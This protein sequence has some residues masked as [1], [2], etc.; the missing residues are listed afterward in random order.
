LIERIGYFCID[1]KCDGLIHG[2]NTSF[3]ISGL[4]WASVIVSATYGHLQDSS[5]EP[6]A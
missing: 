5:L 1:L 2:Y 4:I 3:L 6:I